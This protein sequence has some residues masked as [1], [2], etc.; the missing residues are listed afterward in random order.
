MQ[1]VVKKVKTPSFHEWFIEQGGVC[2]VEVLD[3]EGNRGLFV[4]EGC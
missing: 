4:K 3:K 1:Q 2:N